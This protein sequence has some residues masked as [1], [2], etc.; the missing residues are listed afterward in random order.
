MQVMFYDCKELTNVD[1]SHFDTTNTRY[2]QNMLSG[3][4]K[5]TATIA[6][7]IEIQIVPICYIM[8][9]LYLQQK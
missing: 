1:I 7:K 9:L 3:C 6:I 4:S 8:Q 2:M 5:L